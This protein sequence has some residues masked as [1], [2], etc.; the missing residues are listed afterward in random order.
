MRGDLVVAERAA[1][2]AA[3]LTLSEVLELPCFY[4]HEK[5]SKFERVAVKWISRLSRSASAGS[6]RALRVT[7]L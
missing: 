5:D 4:A 1:R 7:R 3:T 2:E 6:R